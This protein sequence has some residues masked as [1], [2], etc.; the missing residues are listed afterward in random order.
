MEYAKVLF[1]LF[2]FKKENLTLKY[3]QKKG[4]T[5][6]FWRKKADKETRI[7]SVSTQSQFSF[8]HFSTVSKKSGFIVN[9]IEFVYPLHYVC[10]NYKHRCT[11]TVELMVEQGYINEDS[12]TRFSHIYCIPC[13]NSY[14]LNIGFSAQDSFYG[15]RKEDILKYCE[16]RKVCLFYVAVTPETPTPTLEWICKE[17]E[18]VRKILEEYKTDVFVLPF[19]RLINQKNLS[20]LERFSLR[21]RNW[22]I[23][24][25]VGFWLLMIGFITTPVAIWIW[26]SDTPPTQIMTVSI[27]KTSTFESLQFE[28]YT[29]EFVKKFPNMGK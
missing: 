20:F 5:P 9:G 6:F 8:L 15:D 23:L 3:F 24:Q 26:G 19:P 7:R 18:F 13:S 16:E 17:D 29:E 14:P 25:K 1:T 22:D 21:A 11:E 4:S 12:L 27:E 2:S 28:Y 10:N